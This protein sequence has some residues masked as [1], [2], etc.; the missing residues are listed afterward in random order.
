VTGGIVMPNSLPGLASQGGIVTGGTVTNISIQNLTV[1]TK[2]TNA[3]QFYSELSA[4][5]YRDKRG[6]K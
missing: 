3:K 1:T 6:G 4:I 2:A 5:A